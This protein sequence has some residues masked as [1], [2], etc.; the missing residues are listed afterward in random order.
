MSQKIRGI[1]VKLRGSLLAEPSTFLARNFTNYEP[2]GGCRTSAKREIM[3]IHALQRLYQISPKLGPIYVRCTELHRGSTFIYEP[4]YSYAAETARGGFKVVGGRF[5]FSSHGSY[6]S[7]LERTDLSRIVHDLNHSIVAPR[8][9]LANANF[10][11]M[12]IAQYN[13]MRWEV[14]RRSG[15]AGNKGS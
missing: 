5:T 7:H 1:K 10:P 3:L 6:V 11:R 2:S 13:H 9:R 12:G 15:Y 14:V 4:T 8:N